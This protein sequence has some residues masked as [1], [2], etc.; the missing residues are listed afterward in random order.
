MLSERQAVLK[1]DYDA[2]RKPPRK[3]M[4]QKLGRAGYSVEWCEARRSPSG[5]GWHV[6]IA[7]SPR[8][9]TAMEV[10]ALQ[11]MLGSDPWREAMQIARARAFPKCPRFMRD[12]WNVL[13]RSDKRR[14]R[15]LNVRKALSR[16]KR[17]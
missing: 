10:V 9:R 8:P 15:R 11:A 7:V 14:A 5:K 6:L 3:S 17:V 4:M 16:R 2:P 12:A 13:Y 1:L